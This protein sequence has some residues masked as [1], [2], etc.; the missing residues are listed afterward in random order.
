MALITVEDV[1]DAMSGVTFTPEQE[2]DLRNRIDEVQ[3]E[4][5]VF[6][7]RPVQ[8]VTITETLVPDVEGNVYFAST[9]VQVL[10]TI[11][12]LAPD[13]QLTL[14]GYDPVLG[15][16]TYATANTW[17]ATGFVVVYDAGIVG[18]GIGAVKAFMKRVIADEMTASHDDT[19]T[20]KDLTASDPGS[21][22]TRSPKGPAEI[23]YTRIKNLR[24]PF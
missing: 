22:R 7:R 24:R 10:T 6:L 4:V 20:A 18:T 5:E 14:R 1:R 8:T 17:S 21:E 11:D 23:D 12:G 13:G 3:S 15:G 16:W 9:P 19:L 2:R